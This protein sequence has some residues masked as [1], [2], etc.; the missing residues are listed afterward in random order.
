VK[1]IIIGAGRGRRLEHLTEDIPKTLVPILGK[2]MLDSI[3]E[4]LHA[5]GFGPADT[6]FIAGYRGEL[7][8][9][10]HPELEFVENA[11]WASNNILLSL[12]HAREHMAHGF[13]STYAD[14]V[15]DPAV[16]AELVR[17]KHDITLACDRAWRRRYQSRL[18]HPENDAEKMRV[19]GQAD[20]VRETS[21]TVDSAEAAGEFIGVM[22]LSPAG[23][24][25]FLCAF[26]QVLGEQGLDSVFRAGRSLRKAYLIDLLQ[27]MLERGVEM[28]AVYT[29][30]G[31]M[32]I[33]TT[34]DAAHAE[35]WWRERP[36]PG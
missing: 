3:L 32:E 7:V 30:G 27:H 31:Y 25:R 21:R 9:A 13:V 2:P 15:Y 14:I 8:R 16:V 34:E 20:R 4:A 19:E 35:R 24:E 12:L 26:D 5:G 23:V 1:A 6:V 36:R 18:Q 17:S 28:H 33:D 29:D 11:E 10:A 22:R